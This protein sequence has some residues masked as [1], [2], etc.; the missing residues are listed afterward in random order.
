MHVVLSLLLFVLIMAVIFAVCGWIAASILIRKD[1]EYII[2]E[3]R[4]KDKDGNVRK[5]LSVSDKRVMFVPY[6]FR[7]YKTMKFK[8]KESI[9]FEYTLEIDEELLIE[10]RHVFL[11]VDF[12]VPIENALSIYGN[13]NYNETL[14]SRKGDF[15]IKTMEDRVDVNKVQEE[16]ITKLEEA[17]SGIEFSSKAIES[18]AIEEKQTAIPTPVEEMVEC[19]KKKGR[20]KRS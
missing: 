3:K 6:F 14:I 11:F 12:Y 15:F 16:M 19:N 4:V 18:V 2:V 5:E 1:D 10:R 13:L 7:T 9:G 8:S 20:K 17:F